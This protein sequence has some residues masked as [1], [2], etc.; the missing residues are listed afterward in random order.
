MVARQDHVARQYGSIVAPVGLRAHNGVLLGNLGLC[1][2]GLCLHDRCV[3]G[4][5]AH[6]RLRER[7]VIVLGLLL[8][9][10]AGDPGE[11]GCGTVS[12]T[13]LTM[14][15]AFGSAGF[16]GDLQD[17]MLIALRTLC[18][19]PTTAAMA[20]W[21]VVSR[22]IQDKLQRGIGSK[23]YLLSRPTASTASAREPPSV[24]QLPS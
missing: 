9:R 3:L 17:A 8:P 14:Q 2:L 1:H 10:F 22:Q 19:L 7:V 12:H 18:Q 5:D 24:S 6:Q 11:F 13:A 15:V 20:A 21:C 4:R 23:A 16:S